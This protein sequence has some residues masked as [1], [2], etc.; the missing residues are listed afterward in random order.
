MAIVRVQQIVSTGSAMYVN[1]GFVPSK[2]QIVDLTALSTPNFLGFSRAEWYNTMANGSAIVS[3]LDGGQYEFNSV[4]S[5]GGVTPFQSSDA[6][7]WI[8]TVRIISDITQA[9]QAQVTSTAH[10][11]TSADVG[12]TTVTFSSVIGMSQI[13][14]LRGVIQSVIDANKFTVNINSSAFS[15]YVSGGQA[16]VITGIPPYTINGFQVF[17]TPQRN[18]GFIGVNLGSS[19]VGLASDILLIT[20]FL[21]ADFT[22]A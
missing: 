10:G 4:I 8:E 18:D 17:N 14:T 9:A 5:S 13:N 12:V 22:S 11:F 19:V 15:A 7:L 20:A 16:N 6:S 21:D 3:T 2:L 1:F